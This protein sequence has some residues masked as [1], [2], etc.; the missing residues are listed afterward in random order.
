V[1][2]LRRSAL[3]LLVTLTT[4]LALTGTAQAAFT[5]KATPTTLTVGTLTVA[6][7][8]GL[9]ISG[10]SCSTTYWSRT[11]NGQ[12]SSGTSITLHTRISW[13]ASSTTRGLSGYRITARYADGS[14][15][16]VGDVGPTTTSAQLTV[17]GLTANQNIQLTVST[18]TSYGWTAESPRS[19]ALTC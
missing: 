16:P 13:Q 1:N 15:A 2:A 3:L 6:A 8:T 4:V 12:T 9:T 11:I 19:A 17:D 18:L 14:T 10:S 5:G 7:P